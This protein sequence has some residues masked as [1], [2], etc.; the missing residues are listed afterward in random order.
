MPSI[1][2]RVCW[3]AC[4]TAVALA[5][6]DWGLPS[7]A[8]DATLFATRSAWD[9]KTLAAFDAERVDATRGAD[10]DRDPLTKS[11]DPTV[12][13]ATDA[14][15]AEIVRRYRLF[16]HQ[17][18]EMITFMALQQ[19]NPAAG[20]LDPRLYQY[21]GAW[22]YPVGG[23]LKLAGL[24]GWVDVRADKAFY[25]DRPEAFGRFYVVAR[26]YTLAAYVLTMTLAAMIA[27]RLTGSETA[28]ACGAGVVGALPVVFALAHEAKPHLAGTALILATALAGARWV[29]TGKTRD[30]L[31]CGACAGLAAGMVLSAVLALVIPLSMVFLPRAAPID[32]GRD[33]PSARV[34]ALLTALAA[35]AFVFAATNPYVVVHAIYR[36]PVL[37]SNLGNSRAMYAVG[38]VSD[39]L[40]DGSWRLLEAMSWPALALAAGGLLVAVTRR[41]RTTAL[42]ILLAIPTALVLLQF[43]LFAAGKPSEYAR[44]ALLPATVLGLLGVWALST[45]R[46][47]GVQAFVLITAP[48]AVGLAGTWPYVSA[49]AAD[50]TG[51]NTRVSASAALRVVGGGT[52]QVNAEPAPY[53]VPPVDLWAWQLVLTPPGGPPVGDAIVRA[54][55]DPKALGPVPP[56][57]R[58]QV[59]APDR[60]API[61]WA[62]KPFELLV[63]ERP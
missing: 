29:R 26:L 58:R 42:G 9:G 59:I 53:G 38:T 1:L 57:Y 36:D 44:F 49:F 41:S 7:S 60:P 25:Y 3:I 63:R 40:F 19:M 6:V 47:A 62:N 20:Q 23:L 30:A 46:W 48:L 12:L 18:D 32:R 22:I 2:W 56:G 10:V 14:A 21:G 15:R 28:A 8:A 33:S 35:A 16:S 52:L 34:I 5:G 37:A 61:T 55:D 17:P 51:D 13:N 27:W 24:A 31:L 11:A 4:L 39:V 45:I 50:T 43:F 54:I